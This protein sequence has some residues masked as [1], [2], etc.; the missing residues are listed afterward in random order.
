MIVIHIK[1]VTSGHGWLKIL[2]IILGNTF[3][4]IDC[5]F[6][7]VHRD[8]RLG[9]T[10][11]SGS[12]RSRDSNSCCTR[13]L[14]GSRELSSRCGSKSDEEKLKAHDGSKEAANGTVTDRNDG[15]ETRLKRS[16]GSVSYGLF[17]CARIIELCRTLGRLQH[18]CSL[19][20]LGNN[21]A[22]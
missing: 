4:R 5:S 1:K 18:F 8:R 2:R 21:D 20:K 22:C 19:C 15:A 16:G 3:P 12:S 10:C 7:C 14:D 17:S 11:G 13:A 9:H 6:R